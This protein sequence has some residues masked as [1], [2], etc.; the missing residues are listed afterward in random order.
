[1]VNHPSRLAANAARY[2]ARALVIGAARGL[3]RELDMAGVGSDVLTT[4]EDLRAAI[5]ALDDLNGGQPEL[6]SHAA[7]EG[8]TR[9]DGTCPTEYDGIM[10][11]AFRAGQIIPRHRR[12]LDCRITGKDELTIRSAPLGENVRVVSQRFVFSGDWLECISV[13]SV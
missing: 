3:L 13:E 9:P 10:L 5:V 6:L 8:W 1:M 2:A 11:L 12:V 7:H 4:K